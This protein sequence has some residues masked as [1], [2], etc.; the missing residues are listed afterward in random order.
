[1]H[2]ARTRNAWEG[3][4]IH[5]VC[6][7]GAAGIMG[8]SLSTLCIRPPGTTS[9]VEGS[10][11]MLVCTACCTKKLVGALKSAYSRGATQHLS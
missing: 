10:C 11:S 1:M 4:F 6:G 5:H 3:K 2:R 8:D 9:T 7:Y